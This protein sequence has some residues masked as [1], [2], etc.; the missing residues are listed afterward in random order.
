TADVSGRTPDGAVQQASG[1]ELATFEVPALKPE[2]GLLKAVE[3]PLKLGESGARAFG[4]LYPAGTVMDPLS[5]AV[6]LDPVAVLP[7]LP[8]I[9][10]APAAAPAPAAASPAPTTA[11]VAAE[12]AGGAGRTAAAI[13]G[14]LLVLA[15]GA[16]G[17]VLARRRRRAAGG[18]AAPAAAG[19]ATTDEDARPTA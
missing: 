8:D 12:A 1:V 15:L 18:G 17:G 5:F 19:P 16:A 4:G 13:V 11:P 10:S 6:A 2:S 14:G 9:G 7:P 3:L